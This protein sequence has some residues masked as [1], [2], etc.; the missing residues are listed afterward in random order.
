M[1]IWKAP[2]SPQKMGKISDTI[3]VVGLSIFIAVTI[4]ACLA[5][6]IMSIVFAYCIWI[7]Y[8]NPIVNVANVTNLATGGSVIEFYFRCDQAN[9]GASAQALLL[10]CGVTNFQ[11]VPHCNTLAL[12]NYYYQTFAMG[13][14]ASCPTGYLQGITSTA[15]LGVNLVALASSMMILGIFIVWVPLLV[16][17][18]ILSR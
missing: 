11:I 10:N 18:C 14:V 5:C 8:P 13:S 6:F 16:V 4:A 17:M 1:G 7:V 15:N 3:G 12:Q 9:G 2:G